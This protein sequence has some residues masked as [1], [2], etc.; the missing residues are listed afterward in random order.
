MGGR[1]KLLFSSLH[2]RTRNLVEVVVVSLAI[3]SPL[4]CSSDDD[5]GGSP[6]VV[7]GIEGAKRVSELTEAEATQFCDAADAAAKGL[8]SDREACTMGAMFFSE[9]PDDC[10]MI[11]EQCTT[12]GS[13]EVGDDVYEEEAS[14]CTLEDTT[15]REACDA[16]VGELETCF[17]ATLAATQTLV[18]SLT[19][20]AVGAADGE[21]MSAVMDMM[22][23]ADGVPA[24]VPECASIQQKCPTL[25]AESGAASDSTEGGDVNP[26][27]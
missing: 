17:T 9:T 24:G 26:G 13:V 16:T 3:M 23:S 19:C 11:V 2:I 8:I 7:S 21:G 20:D 6:E 22:P 10:R 25:V 15:K 4:A 14:S 12:A 1:K 18:Q 27:S 5:G